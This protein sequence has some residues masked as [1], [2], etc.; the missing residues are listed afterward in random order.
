MA[1]PHSLSLTAR[2]VF[3]RL[4]HWP[5]LLC[6]GVV[7]GAW[8]AGG[9]PVKACSTTSRAAWC[10]ARSV[11]GWCKLRAVWH[12]LAG[13]TARVCCGRELRSVR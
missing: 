9:S 11:R 1:G 5:V 10:A 6:C 2:V 4:I 7:V 13:A 8:P 12:V 3:W